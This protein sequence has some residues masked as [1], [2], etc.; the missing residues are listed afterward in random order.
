MSLSCSHYYSFSCHSNCRTITESGEHGICIPLDLVTHHSPM[1]DRIES[2]MLSGAYTIR[3]P[4]LPLLRFLTSSQEE[5]NIDH[6]APRSML[7]FNSYG[8]V[9]IGLVRGFR[10][11]DKISA[12]VNRI[13]L[14]RV[15]IIAFFH[16]DTIPRKIS[17]TRLKHSHLASRGE[18]SGKR[19]L[20]QP[21]SA[22]I[23]RPPD[24]RVR[25]RLRILDSRS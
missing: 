5:I 25:P 17:R 9:G 3:C 1:S 2:S 4:F 22:A 6:K 23:I 12:C 8:A 7:N 19:N 24:A 21:V 20:C 15:G 11:Q 10:V 14:T 16:H 13:P 18:R